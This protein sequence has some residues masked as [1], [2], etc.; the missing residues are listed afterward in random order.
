M[1]LRALCVIVIVCSLLDLSEAACAKAAKK[2]GR[3]TRLDNCNSSILDD[4]IRG[5]LESTMAT[6]IVP[7]F[8]SIVFILGLPANGIALWVLVFK[9]KKIPSTLLLMNLAAADLLF[10][11][12]LPFKITYHFLGNN[13]IFGEALCRIVTAVFYGNMYCS[14]FFLTVISVDRYFALVHPFWS[15]G[16]RSWRSSTAISIGIWLV[17]IAGV[18]M[19]LFVPQ[20][21]TFT[22]P[23]ITTCHEIWPHCKGY[24]WYTNYFIV[25]FIVGYVIPLVAILFSYVP[26]LVT[27]ATNRE[28]HRHVIRLIILV[29]LMFILCFTP[30]NILLILHYLETDWD[31]HNQLY[32]WYTVALSLTSFN[33]CIDPFIYYYI[34]ND[35]WVMVKDTLCINKEG[36]SESSESTKRTRIPC[37]SDNK[38]MVRR[39]DAY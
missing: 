31:C 5:H 11:L 29:L 17:V 10:M 15:K 8:Y 3:V 20:T 2:K 18:S 33:S 7:S 9:A 36:N 16:V 22:S 39:T 27:L 25:L 26:I 30:S 35:F 32:I 14:V 13:W 1:S 19:F 4:D 37:S 21:K 6:T 28:S 23:G 24:E 38:E 12:A 34:S